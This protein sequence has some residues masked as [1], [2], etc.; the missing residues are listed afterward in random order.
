MGGT[1]SQPYRGG[2]ASKGSKQNL[3][4]KSGLAERAACSGLSAQR[5]PVPGWLVRGEAA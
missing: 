4:P 1:T 5:V 3:F 2:V